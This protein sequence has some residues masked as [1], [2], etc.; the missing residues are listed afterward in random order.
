MVVNSSTI[1][2]GTSNNN[3]KADLY[4]QSLIDYI[5]D[6]VKLAVSF[7]PRAE[8]SSLSSR[9]GGWNPSLPCFRFLGLVSGN[10]FN[11]TAM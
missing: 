9:D 5:T 11:L 1:W 7:L 2:L 3:R 8:I 6:D 10:R 4:N